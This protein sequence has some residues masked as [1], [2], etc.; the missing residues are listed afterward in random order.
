MSDR[1]NMDVSGH[2]ET[3][4]GFLKVT[5]LGSIAVIAIVVLMAITLL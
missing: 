1:G 2:S 4:A 3:Y 5:T